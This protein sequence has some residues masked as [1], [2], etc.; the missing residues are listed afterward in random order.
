[1]EKFYRIMWAGF[2]VNVASGL[3][4]LIADAA[5]KFVNW[6]FYVKLIFVAGAVVFLKQLRRRLFHNPVA[7]PSA[8]FLAIGLLIC[9]TGAIIAGRL[10]AYLGPVSG[11][12]GYSNGL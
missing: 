10:M 1:M 12:P 3:V 2:W 11:A 4:L 7:V 5:T 9:W 8:K 6:D